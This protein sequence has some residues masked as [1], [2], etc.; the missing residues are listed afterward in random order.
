MTTDLTV[1]SGAP[2]PSLPRSLGGLLQEVADQA[3]T[4][5]RRVTVS[6]RLTPIER[7]AA[8]D[9]LRH[10]DA[11]LSAPRGGRAV[12]VEIA[13]ML[14]GFSITSNM[15]Q[16]QA[17]AK[18]AVYEDAVGDLPAWTIV[19]ARKAWAR[20][21]TEGLKGKVDPSFPPAPAH[22]RALALQAMSPPAAEAARLRALLGAEV[23][24]PLPVEH[25][26]EMLRRMSGL[27]QPRTMPAP[28]RDMTEAERA[29]RL[30]A[31]ATEV[32][33][34]HNPVDGGGGG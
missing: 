13:G 32:V 4:V 2:T 14:S 9:R 19:A 6:R 5:P 31:M 18:A 27:M 12:M 29:N 20:G 8:Q 34:E 11:L 22:V 10:L 16:L 33:R 24:A 3:R 26:R 23:V 25:R 21:E 7:G 1:N 15:S 17:D 28:E 30:A